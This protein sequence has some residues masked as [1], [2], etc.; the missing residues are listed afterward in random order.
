MWVGFGSGDLSDLG[1]SMTTRTQKDDIIERMAVLKALKQP[2]GSRVRPVDVF[3]LLRP[4]GE[5]GR[6]HV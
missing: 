5:I 1:V 3:R 2:D 6:A 4:S